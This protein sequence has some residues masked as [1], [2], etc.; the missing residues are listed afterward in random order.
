MNESVHNEA[1]Q[2]LNCL[3]LNC[4]H[5]RVYLAIV[6]NG[7]S[8]AKE[9]SKYSGVNRQEIYRIMPKL[10]KLGLAEKIISTPTKWKAIPLQ[11]GLSF[12]L[13]RRKTETSELQIKSI[14]IIN[15]FME[16]NGVER[17]KEEFQFVMLEK[18]AARRW[19]LKTLEGTQTSNDIICTV[20]NF[21]DILYFLS[22]FFKKAMKRG[23]K[24]RLVLYK[25]ENEKA[26]LNVDEEFKNTPNFRVRYI[27]GTP[28][29]S[30]GVHDKKKAIISTTPKDP[31]EAPSLCS[32][33]PVFV[34]TL[35]N[36]FETLWKAALRN[37]EKCRNCPN[38]I[39]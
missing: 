34:A 4:S 37:E 14:K 39:S 7:V 18:G 5:A 33:N 20:K 38:S 3:G 1:V 10:Q 26:M 17:Q 16:N 28:S 11:D 8:T 12:L 32:N 13:E 29:A 15:N 19:L 30:M 23:V 6:K 27:T 25:N 24:F 35:D 21:N 31:D 36:Y 22:D 2:I 9:I